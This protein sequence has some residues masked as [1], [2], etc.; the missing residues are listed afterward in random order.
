MAG[1]NSRTLNTAWK[2]A[3]NEDIAADIISYIRTMAMGTS[4]ISHEERIKRAVDKVRSQREWTKVQQK[5]LDR[6]EKQLIQEIVLQVEDLDESPFKADGGYKRLNKIFN[7]ELDSII[8]S[9]NENLYIE[10]A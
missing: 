6:F 7:N 4:L 2:E 5:W 9:I 10:I 3:K 8:E 1:F